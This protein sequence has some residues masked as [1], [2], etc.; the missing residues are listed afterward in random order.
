[1]SELDD[2]THSLSAAKE[3]NIRYSQMS[4]EEAA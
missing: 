4:E 2:E 3:A 1:M